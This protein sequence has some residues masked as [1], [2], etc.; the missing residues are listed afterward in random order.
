MVGRVVS[1]AAAMRR[2]VVLVSP[3][4]LDLTSAP[5]RRSL[6]LA[7]YLASRGFGVTVFCKA[8]YSD[9]APD[10]IVGHDSVEF[11]FIGTRQRSNSRSLISRAIDELRFSLGTVL[12]LL[13]L[14][15]LWMVVFSVPPAL[16]LISVYALQLL[17]P[18][19][20]QIVVD[21]RD[22]YPE[23]IHYAGLLSDRHPLIRLMQLF[24]RGVYMHSDYVTVATRSIGC[25]VARDYDRPDPVVWYNGSPHDMVLGEFHGSLNTLPEMT[26][27]ITHGTLGRFQDVSALT[28]FARYLLQQQRN[29]IRIVVAGDGV[30]RYLIEEGASDGL[31]IRYSGI[32]SS[33]ELLGAI[34]SATIG[35]SIRSGDSGSV[36]A[37]PVRVFEYLGR[38]LPVIIVPDGE[39]GRHVASATAGVV[40][41]SFTPESLLRAVDTIV[42]SPETYSR[43]R[44]NSLAL[45]KSFI[46]EQC[47]EAAW[48][49]ILD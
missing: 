17:R 36:G 22:L 10:R 6:S 23:V 39:A 35:L 11:S 21:V 4:F 8:G 12:R 42:A 40:L 15:R 31:P 16:P 38:A 48:Q 14:S 32:L 29:D 27:L 28:D 41:S 5:S 33:S 30:R 25:V 18:G 3:R 43:Y 49:P 1:G 37:L 20:Q 24:M 7:K 2:R 47:L 44:S 45:A 26:T 9:L 19:R 13:S 46:R 34:D